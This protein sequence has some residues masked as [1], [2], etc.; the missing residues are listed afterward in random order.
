[1]SRNQRM[2]PSLCLHGSS[3]SQGEHAQLLPSCLV[4]PLPQGFARITTTSLGCCSCTIN[5]KCSAPL[6]AGLVKLH[7]KHVGGVQ[8][9]PLV[10][11][12][13]R[14]QPWT[15]NSPRVQKLPRLPKPPP[16]QRSCR[17]PRDLH[18]P[19]LGLLVTD[20]QVC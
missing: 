19:L 8:T 7:A 18:L 13:A 14:S 10:D 17:L 12:L 5:V 6:G 16:R 11:P 9:R 15:A 2:L 3:M 4:A 1:M 20:S